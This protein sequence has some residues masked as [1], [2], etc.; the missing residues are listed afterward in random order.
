MLKREHYRKIHRSLQKSTCNVLLPF[1]TNLPLKIH[2][3][4][5]L[6]LPEYLSK[7]TYV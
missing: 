1:E 3:W 5:C 4:A 6:C 7:Y 2:L